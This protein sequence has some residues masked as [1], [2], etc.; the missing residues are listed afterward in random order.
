[1]KQYPEMPNAGKA[2][3][4]P[5]YIFVKYDGSNIR[6]EWSKK[7]G[8]HKFG[9]RKMMI[10]ETHPGFGPAIPLFKQ[11]YGEDLEK[12]F[13]KSKL[14][15]GV[16][17]VIV[18]CE[19]FGVKSFCGQHEE[20]DPKA[21]VLFD[22]N[23]VK[24]GML[25]PKEFLDEFGHLEIAELCGQMNL[26]EELIQAVRTENFEFMDFRSKLPIANEIPEGVICKGDKGHNLWMCKIKTQRYYDELKR[27]RPLDWE[28]YWE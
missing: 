13:K 2:P 6:A 12:V 15:Q 3:R 16:D 11:K 14:F 5:C 21:I 17:R 20:T 8:W 23:P 24:K 7:R 1:M 25:G 4:K 18:F 28:E 26:N 19:W 10:D 27:R 22:V 9:T